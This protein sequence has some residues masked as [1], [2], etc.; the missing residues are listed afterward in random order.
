MRAV[1]GISPR[2]A[3]QI[4][5]GGSNNVF[6]VVGIAS[7]FGTVLS[8]EFTEKAD[9]YVFEKSNGDAASVL[10]HNV[11]FELEIEALFDTAISALAIGQQVDFPTGSI[12]GNITSIKHSRKNKD[13][14]KV[15][16]TAK[17]WKSMGNVT[18]TEV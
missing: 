2:M 7:V 10:L 1:P 9:E 16:F 3:H 14:R 12:K 8:A 13:G 18:P 17:H 5:L 6:G 11:T 4:L 15:T